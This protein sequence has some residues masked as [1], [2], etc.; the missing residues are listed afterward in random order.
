MA[1]KNCECGGELKFEDVDRFE[2]ES[3]WKCQDCGR[4]WKHI[5]EEPF[6]GQ[7]SVWKEVS[8]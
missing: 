1:E 2:T 7:E 8:F 3:I 5:H 4:F 6:L